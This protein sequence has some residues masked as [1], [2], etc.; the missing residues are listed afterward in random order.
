M[1]FVR[2]EICVCVRYIHEHTQYMHREEYVAS[3]KYVH[4][5]RHIL[6]TPARWSVSKIMHRF[7]NNQA[8]CYLLLWNIQSMNEVRLV[9]C[10]Q[11]IISF[12][13]R[14]THEVLVVASTGA[15]W[16]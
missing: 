13:I 14:T 1:V 5:H 2:Y 6:F 16:D 9:A 12:V 3:T 8:R 10:R 15:E 11:C 4:R 7:H